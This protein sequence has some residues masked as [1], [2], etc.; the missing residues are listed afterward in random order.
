MGTIYKQVEVDGRYTAKWSEDKASLPGAK[1]L[2]RFP[3]RD[4]LA[5]ADESCP[6]GVE[7]LLRPV[8]S[9]G[10]LIEEAPSIA[11]IRQRAAASM[12]RVQPRPV[13]LSSM[14]AALV[15]RMREERK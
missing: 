12:R 10:Q 5:L 2:F 9:G 3:D 8:I 1:Q 4:V 13:E 15:D 14:L 11:A 6:E 7:A